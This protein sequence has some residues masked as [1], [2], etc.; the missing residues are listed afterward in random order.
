M[1]LIGDNLVEGSDKRS[2]GD[3]GN[4]NHYYHYI[5]EEN[6]PEKQHVI[7]I[8]HRIQI[9]AGKLGAETNGLIFSSLTVFMELPIA[10][11]I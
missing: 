10:S 4:R 1:V 5:G 9:A 11:L 2:D 3:C 6:R 7:D 8:G